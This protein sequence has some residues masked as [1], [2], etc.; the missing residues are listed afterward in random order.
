MIDLASA[1]LFRDLDPREAQ[2]LCE[3]AQE[4]TY[5]AGTRIFSENDPGDG[6]YI[7]RDGLVEIAHMVGDRP[8]SVF[9]KLGP[10]EI[11]GEMAI[12]ED[13]PRS[14]TTTATKETHVYFIPQS[15]MAALLKRSPALSFK[16]L[17]EISRRLRDFNQYHLREIIQAERLATLGNF[18]R[19]IVHDLK[20]PLTV[21]SM[22]TEIMSSPNTNPDMRRESYRR[23]KRQITSITELVGDILD[24]TQNGQVQT[25]LP[26]VNFKEF[27]NGVV[28]ELHDE[29][30]FKGATLRLE[31]EPPAIKLKFDP[32]RVRRII[33]NLVENAVDMMPESG[34]VI[35]RFQNSDKE[36]TT[37][38][39]DTGPGIAP[40]IADKLFQAFV[41][42][43]KPHG[44]GLGLSICKKIVEDHGGR[45][46]SRNAPTHGAIFSF[47]LPVRDK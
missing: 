35:L 41:T 5:P 15:E 40:E 44:T 22:A 13:L 37:E 28:E 29:V 6:V 27:I 10:G 8:V 12:I 39:Q 30:D 26:L 18:A 43:G 23:V 19:S 11:F 42:H 31:N 33:F 14:A 7:I 38:V 32:R 34:E 17:Q 1:R 25:N 9:S 3:I 16:L 4:R 2:A 46:S 47:T 20:N 24:F 36:V 21:I 45:I